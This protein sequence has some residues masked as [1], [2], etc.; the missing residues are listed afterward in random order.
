MKASELIKALKESI[1]RYGDQ[2]V[3][4]WSP[5]ESCDIRPVSN[6]RRMAVKDEDVVVIDCHRNWPSTTGEPSGSGRDNNR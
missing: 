1:D 6:L 3:C 4:T 5:T 2:N